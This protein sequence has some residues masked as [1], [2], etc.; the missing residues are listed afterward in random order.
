MKI[1]TAVFEEKMKKSIAN[2]EY[3]FGSISSTPQT[4]ACPATMCIANS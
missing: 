1:E 2:L 3:E 4:T